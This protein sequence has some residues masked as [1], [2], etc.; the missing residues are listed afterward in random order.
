QRRLLSSFILIRIPPPPRSAFFPYTTLFRSLAKLEVKEAPAR[1]RVPGY[2]PPARGIARYPWA[3]TFLTLL[4]IGL[5]AFTLYFYHL[6]PFA[7][8]AAKSK[9]V[10][11]VSPTPTSTPSPCL[12]VVKQLTDNAPAP[13]TATF[14]KTQHTYS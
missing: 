2:K 7:L 14:N 13:D 5:G 3:S 11:H 9:P 12:A 4:I 8:P 1:K 10:V 6:G